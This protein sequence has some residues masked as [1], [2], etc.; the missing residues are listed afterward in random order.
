[1]HI[2]QNYSTNVRVNAIAPG[3]AL[4]EQNR[5]LLTDAQTGSPTKRGNTI[6]SHTPMNRYFEP[7]ELVGTVIWL[8]SPASA[9]VH[10][11]TVLV[12][13]GFCAFSGV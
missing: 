3:F 8:L 5:F 13:G 10:G 12:D 9:F 7:Q 1:V 11:V 4:T 2:S 6:I